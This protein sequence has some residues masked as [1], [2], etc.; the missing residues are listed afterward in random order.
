[1]ATTGVAV[2]V[3]RE[4][5]LDMVLVEDTQNGNSYSIA[6]SLLQPVASF[7]FFRSVRESSESTGLP[8]HFLIAST[9]FPPPCP[10][11]SWE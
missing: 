3:G 2:A 10:V 5:Y 9:A 6:F 1:M 11:G 4:S 8:L 7:L